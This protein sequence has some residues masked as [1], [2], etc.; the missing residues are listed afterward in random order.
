MLLS[1]L[2]IALRAGTVAL[3]LVLAAALF[4]GFGTGLAGRLAA[5]FALGSAAHAVLLPA[6]PALAGRGD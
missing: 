1:T 2:E 3:L 6:G 5:F 4:S